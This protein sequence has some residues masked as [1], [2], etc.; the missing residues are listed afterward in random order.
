MQ[1]MKNSDDISMNN[2]SS[3]GD[4]TFQHELEAFLSHSAEATTWHAERVIKQSEFETTELVEGRPRLGTAGRYIRKV[5]DAASGAGAAYEELWRAQERGVHLT[6]VP[7]LVECAHSGT[8]LTV[9]MEHVDGCTVDALQRAVGA[10]ELLASMVL[11][12]LSRS[13]GELH[14]AFDRPLIHRDLKPSNVIMREGEAVIIDFGSARTWSPDASSDTTHFLTRCYAPPEQFGFG[15]TDERS[16]VYAM[17]KILYFCLTGEQPPNVCGASECQARGMGEEWAQIIETACAFDPTARY[18]SAA[19]F[20][21]AVEF[22]VKRF[23]ADTALHAGANIASADQR[24][25]PAV[26]EG[27]THGVRGGGAPAFMRS[28]EAVSAL[29]AHS[30]GASPFARIPVWMGRIWNALVLT[31]LVAM[32]WMSVEATFNPPPVDAGKS[33][34][35]LFAQN[36]MCIDPMLIIGSYLIL[37]RRRIRERYP[38]LA[39]WGVL[40]ETVYGIVA[41]AAV[42][43]FSA[44]VV[45]VMGWS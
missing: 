20:G 42:L 43:L 13:V 4:A 17:G 26:G 15:Q 38:A 33:I 32:L 25:D 14:T 30:V 8:T 24:V 21:S 2:A 22:I 40:R 27:R 34:G 11:P 5:I 39:R 18:A 31:F 23:F 3:S 9:V 19:E 45:A 41:M 12:A 29:C 7:R 35:Y 1:A 16:D 10:G 36:I 28:H 44:L 37:D 6:C